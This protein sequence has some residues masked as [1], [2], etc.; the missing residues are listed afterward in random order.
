MPKADEEDEEGAVKY[1]A[2][3]TG[4][5]EI[6][7]RRSETNVSIPAHLRVGIRGK[8]HALLQSYNFTR[9][10]SAIIIADITIMIYETDQYAACATHSSRK[11]C[12]DT[13]LEIP[14][15]VF[16]A[17]YSVEAIVRVYVFRFPLFCERWNL[18]DAAVVIA[19]Y[20]D[21]AM[22][23]Y[24]ADDMPG[25]G[26]ALCRNFRIVLMVASMLLQLVFFSGSLFNWG[27]GCVLSMTADY[28]TTWI[29]GAWTAR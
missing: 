28:T 22:R 15:Y 29:M 17:I 19:G 9:L 3:P 1:E 12:Q 10:I 24:W 11:Q 2:S 23:Q 16:L 7:G 8:L 13:A 6:S 26:M 25:P 5:S 18:L 27:V 21:I 4:K 20:M 14:N